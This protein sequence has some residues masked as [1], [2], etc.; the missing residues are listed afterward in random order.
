MCG[1]QKKWA[2]EL[3]EAQDLSRRDLQALQARLDEEHA[4]KAQR[5]RELHAAMAETDQRMQGRGL[6][7]RGRCSP[8]VGVLPPANTC[9][10]GGKI[11]VGTKMMWTTW[12][13]SLVPNVSFNFQDAMRQCVQRTRAAE[14]RFLR[15]TCSVN[16]RHRVAT[17]CHCVLCGTDKVRSCRLYPELAVTIQNPLENNSRGLCTKFFVHFQ[18]AVP[19]VSLLNFGPPNLP[20]P[21]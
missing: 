18:E 2:A 4:T 17:R 16:L 3:R 5:E 14:G 15:A 8:A 20:H 11:E 6:W 1:E 9:C 13:L 21:L 12:K 10:I 19:K 7:P